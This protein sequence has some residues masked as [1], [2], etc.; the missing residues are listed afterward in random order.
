[1]SGSNINLEFIPSVF[2]NRATPAP[3]PTNSAS[4]FSGGASNASA[5]ANQGMFANFFNPPAQREQSML[6]D[7]SN[8]FSMSYTKVE[9]LGRLLCFGVLFSIGLLFCFLST[10]MILSPRTFAKFYTLG[11]LCILFRYYCI[12]THQFMSF[13]TFFLVS[14]KAQLKR[15][16]DPSRFVAA[17]AYL[18]SMLATLWAALIKQSTGLTLILVIVQFCSALWYGASYIP[19][20]QSCLRSSASTVLP[21]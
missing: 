10:W 5:P 21:I 17:M 20:A 2:S 11:T 4:W 18:V 1:M 14:P 15:L 7:L 6:E 9:G 12:S 13:S 8:E 3:P 16:F 19:F